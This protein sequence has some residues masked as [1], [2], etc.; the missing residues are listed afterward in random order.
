[1]VVLLSVNIE[2]AFNI[3]NL[4]DLFPSCFSR[5]KILI[6]NSISPFFCANENNIVE[7]Q[8]IKETALKSLIVCNKAI[9]LQY[10]AANNSINNF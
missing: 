1:M 8:W 2:T 9:S 7:I 10:T 4:E 6:C 5:F 3:C